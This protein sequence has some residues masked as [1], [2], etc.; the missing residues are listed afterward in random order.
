[1]AQYEVMF[2][3]AAAKQL[4]KLEK[5]DRRRIRDFLVERVATDNPQRLGAALQGDLTG[6]WRY[7]VGDFRIVVVIDDDVVTVAVLKV[8]NRRSVYRR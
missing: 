8:E 1:M 3:R 4:A 5:H 6:L 2:T 7:R